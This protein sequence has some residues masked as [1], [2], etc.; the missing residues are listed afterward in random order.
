MH[1]VPPTNRQP[2]CRAATNGALNGFNYN[3]APPEVATSLRRTAVL[4]LE[5]LSTTKTAGARARQCC[6]RFWPRARL[7]VAP[8]KAYPATSIHL[9]APSMAG[10]TTDIVGRALAQAA[11][12]LAAAPDVGNRVA[13]GEE[14]L[15]GVVVETSQQ[16]AGEGLCQPR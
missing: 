14:R 6:S 2:V 15:E 3:R 11:V 7:H 8:G 4:I 12:P 16:L 1:D 5:K 10:G 13:M 9:I